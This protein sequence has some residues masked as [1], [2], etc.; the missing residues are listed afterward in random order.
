MTVNI[1]VDYKKV[2]K[3]PEKIFSTYGKQVEH[4]FFIIPPFKILMKN[5]KPAKIFDLD[6]FFVYPSIYSFSSWPE[7][8]ALRAMRSLRRALGAFSSL[9]KQTPDS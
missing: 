8:P 9:M 1:H 2:F 4:L 6:W 3:D 7:S 5:S